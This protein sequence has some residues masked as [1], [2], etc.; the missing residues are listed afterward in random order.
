MRGPD[1]ARTRPPA[2]VR[3]PPRRG[4]PTGPTVRAASDAGERGIAPPARRGTLAPCLT[5]PLPI[6][7]F[8]CG[9]CAKAS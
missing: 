9:G 7:S 6:G 5:T 3:T 2:R 4:R 1:R 8:A